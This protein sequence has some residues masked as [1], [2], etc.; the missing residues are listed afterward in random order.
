MSGQLTA[1]DLALLQAAVARTGQQKTASLI[2]ISRPAVS[3]LLSGK[4]P[5]KDLAP[6]T[7]KIRTA[8]ARVDC[9]HLGRTLALAA[10]QGHR[11]RPVPQSSAAALRHWQACRGCPVGDAHFGPETREPGA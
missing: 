1:A 11:R 5:A 4:Y 2:G 9:P 8:L 3:L 7:A 10:C 6:V